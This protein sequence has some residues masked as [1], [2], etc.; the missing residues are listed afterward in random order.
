MPNSIDYI[1]D[2]TKMPKLHFVGYSLGNTQFFMALANQPEYNE[3]IG[4]HISYAASVFFATYAESNRLFALVWNRPL[5]ILQK[6]I[7]GFPLPPQGIGFMLNQILL[8]ICNPNLDILGV[9]RQ[10]LF[11]IMGFGPEQIS[12]EQT[13][14]ILGHLMT[15]TSLK[16]LVQ[17][18]QFMKNDRLSYYDYGAWQ[19]LR[20][21][22]TSTPPLYNVRNV[23][24]P[25]ALVLAQNDVF[26][27]AQG[28]ERLLKVLPNVVN[29]YTIPSKTF[30]HIDFV[31]ASNANEMV[32][33]HTI[34]LINKFSYVH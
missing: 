23:R 7:G 31:Y 8:R 17:L 16:M 19:N 1:L 9:C 28:Y 20:L 2:V 11:L 6:L 13:P 24:A 32:Y 10:M 21:Y 30:S 12:K 18:N 22:G 3:K 4:I 33:N 15:P 5:Q 34:E 29:S 26:A 27:N 25:T 14:S